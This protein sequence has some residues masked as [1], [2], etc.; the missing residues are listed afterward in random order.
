MTAKTLMTVEQS[1]Y[2]IIV[3]T[4]LIIIITIMMIGN[5]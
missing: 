1:I 4:V 5:C 2:V 3:F